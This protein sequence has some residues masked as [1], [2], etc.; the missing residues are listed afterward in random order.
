MLLE[1]PRIP[2]I[3]AELLFGDEASKRWPH[4]RVVYLSEYHEFKISHLN[5][6]ITSARYVK[7]SQCQ[8]LT[9]PKLQEWQKRN[10]RYDIR[11]HVS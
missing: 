9:F 4:L 1:S 7:I 3:H 8:K 2:E 5:S 6:L 10:Q 11:T